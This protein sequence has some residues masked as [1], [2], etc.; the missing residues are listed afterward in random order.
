MNVMELKALLSAHSFVQ[1]M[2]PEHVQVL[3]D[4]AKIVT[5]QP[6]Q[7][8][9][10]EGEPANEFYLIE[11]GRVELEAHEPA[12][13][14]VIVQM[15]GAD[16]A[17]GWSW[18]LP[19]YVWHLRARVIEPTTAIA[20]SGAHLLVRAENDHEF[21]YDLMKRVATIVMHRLQAARRQLLLHQ[22]PELNLA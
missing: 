21:G 4:C 9:F 11:K 14:T 8:I 22:T 3:F 19:P 2:R 6:G 16:D 18:M 13:G 5:F 12:D 17:M 20:L 7:T 15:L 1:G 10:K